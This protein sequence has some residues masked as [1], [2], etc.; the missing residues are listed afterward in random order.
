MY[1]NTCRVIIDSNEPTKHKILLN[2]LPINLHVL[3][4]RLGQTIALPA[5]KWEEAIA[6]DDVAPNV[7]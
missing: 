7:R 6:A 3:L 1:K 2:L 5:P 4:K